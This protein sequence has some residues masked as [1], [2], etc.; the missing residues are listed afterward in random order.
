MLHVSTGGHQAGVMYTYTSI[1]CDRDRA[2]Q[3]D[4]PSR[5]LDQDKAVLLLS[6]ALGRRAPEAKGEHLMTVV[7][8][9]T[10][11]TASGH[12]PAMGKILS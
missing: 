3:S 10:F 11:D 6:V 4:C 1:L 7:R 5:Q 8:A 2:T 9:N 12:Q